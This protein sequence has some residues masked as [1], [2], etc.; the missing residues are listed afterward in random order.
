MA[1]G[2]ARG[3]GRSMWQREEH[4][5]EAPHVLTDRKQRE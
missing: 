4:V 5:A 1:E 3:G 2:G